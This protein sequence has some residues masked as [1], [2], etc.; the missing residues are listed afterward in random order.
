M[1]TEHHADNALINAIVHDLKP[2]A[3]GDRLIATGLAD[4]PGLAMDAVRGMWLFHG[5]RVD[6]AGLRP[7][8]VRLLELP[9]D[10]GTIHVL[11]TEEGRRVLVASDRGPDA[12]REKLDRARIEVTWSQEGGHGR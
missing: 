11:I 5:V 6:P 10:G 9:L 8:R 4:A 3:I 7:Q 12:I 1:H 2:D